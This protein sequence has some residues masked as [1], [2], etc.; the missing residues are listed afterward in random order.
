MRLV[1]Y[2]SDTL[3]ENEAH[4]TQVSS[5]SSQWRKCIFHSLGACIPCNACS[6]YQWVCHGTDKHSNPQVDELDMTF[7]VHV[8]AQENTKMGYSIN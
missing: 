5:T 2:E 4:H 1:V 6:S 3:S 7:Q 8:A